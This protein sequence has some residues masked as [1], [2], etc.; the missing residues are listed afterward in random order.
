MILRSDG[1]QQNLF[2]VLTCLARSMDVIDSRL[3]SCHHSRVSTFNPNP[4]KYHR[5][6]VNRKGNIFT[7]HMGCPTM[8]MSWCN[9]VSSYSGVAAVS[10]GLTRSAYE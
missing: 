10:A 3:G 4:K 8:M 2:Y 9:A 1:D 7:C 5:T 6:N